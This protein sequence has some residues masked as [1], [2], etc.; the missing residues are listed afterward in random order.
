MLVIEPQI[1]AAIV[2]AVVAAALS[3]RRFR[4]SAS[5]T[6]HTALATYALVLGS[7]MALAG[8]LHTGAVIGSAREHAKAYD[9]RLV[10]LLLIGGILVFCGLLNVG[11]SSRL[12]KAM[13]WA[14]AVTLFATVAFIVFLVLLLPLPDAGSLATS[15]LVL[16]SIY[17]LLLGGVW[18]TVREKG[19][20]GA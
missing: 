14:S 2:V 12:N 3:F 9:S 10:Y 13:G 7:V 18:L 1:P 17:L 4:R 16:N 6:R 15:L 5:S 11:L 20:P 19:P 8:A